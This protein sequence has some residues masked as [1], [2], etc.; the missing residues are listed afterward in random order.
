MEK[1]ER[2]EKGGREEKGEEGERGEEKGEGEREGRVLSKCIDPGKLTIPQKKA[3]HPRI[4]GQ[5]KLM[6]L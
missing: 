4:F 1:R 2:R 3:T 5:H 6:D